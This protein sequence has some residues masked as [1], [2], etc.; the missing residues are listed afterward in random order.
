M[1]ALRRIVTKPWMQKKSRSFSERKTPAQ[2]IQFAS[3]STEMVPVWVTSGSFM[4]IHV[5]SLFISIIP[6]AGLW[7]GGLY[8]GLFDPKAWNTLR[9]L[10]EHL[11]R[12]FVLTPANSSDAVLFF[13]QCSGCR[14]WQKPTRRLDTIGMG[15]VGRRMMKDVDCRRACSTWHP[16]IA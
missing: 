11:F 6:L 9:A 5:Y 12:C 1:A 14:T 4:Y 2:Y 7:F 15:R 8:L 3:K 13:Q 16:Q 10:H